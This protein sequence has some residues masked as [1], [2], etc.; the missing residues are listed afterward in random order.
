MVQYSLALLLAPCSFPLLAP[1]LPSACAHSGGL[2]SMGRFFHLSALLICQTGGTDS[3]LSSLAQLGNKHWAPEEYPVAA[4]FPTGVNARIHSLMCRVLSPAKSSQASTNCPAVCPR[5]ITANKTPTSNSGFAPGGG[6]LVWAG[7]GWVPL[8]LEGLGW[9]GWGAH[10]S[11]SPEK[12]VHATSLGL[13]WCQSRKE[14]GTQSS[15]TQSR[16]GP[17]DFS[18]H[19]CLPGSTLAGSW[20]LNPGTPV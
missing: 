5:S 11:P 8:L 13:S 16:Q 3:S 15:L 4:D 17:H 18:H 2:A 1:P 7:Q 6:S 9:L 20:E 19:H 10:I 14:L 12:S